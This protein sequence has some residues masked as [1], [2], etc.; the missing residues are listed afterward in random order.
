LNSL[1]TVRFSKR[2]MLRGVFVINDILIIVLRDLVNI[3]MDFE[4]VSKAGNF[5]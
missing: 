2:T 1:A 5:Y 3:A 4:V